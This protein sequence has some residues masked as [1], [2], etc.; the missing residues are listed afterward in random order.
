V[1]KLNGGETMLEYE[2]TPGCDVSRYR[3]TIRLKGRLTAPLA[4][5]FEQL[6]L[7]A[8]VAP[9]ET[10]VEGPVDDDAALFGLLRRIEALGLELIEVRQVDDRGATI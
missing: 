10:V 8:T 9:V 5:E 6:H 4:S 2:A 7:S 1:T 3:Y